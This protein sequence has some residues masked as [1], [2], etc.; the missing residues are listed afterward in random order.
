[1]GLNGLWF[2]ELSL[3]SLSSS[4]EE[5]CC[6]WGSGIIAFVLTV[7]VV[8]F[9]ASWKLLSKIYLF[10]YDFFEAEVIL[11]LSYISEVM[12]DSP[13]HHFSLPSVLSAVVAQL[14]EALC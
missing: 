14:L 2:L 5:F 7:T 13:Q 3:Y 8:L 4:L 6:P 1:M 12:G 10:S 11:V 9:L